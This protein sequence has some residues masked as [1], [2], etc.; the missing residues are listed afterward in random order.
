[1]SRPLMRSRRVFCPP[2]DVWVSVTVAGRVS[3]SWGSFGTSHNTDQVTDT[4]AL[5]CTLSASGGGGQCFLG[6]GHGPS[7]QQRLWGQTALG[8]L[9]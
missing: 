4:Q 2:G 9:T 7:E 3:R 8:V 6:T 5:I 1:M